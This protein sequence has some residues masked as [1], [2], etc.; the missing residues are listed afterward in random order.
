MARRFYQ[1]PSLTGLNTFDACARHGSFTAAAS[2][3]GV[4]LG[5]VSRQVKALES[6]LDCP[7]FLRLHRGVEL[8]PAGIDLFQTLSSSFQQIGRLCQEFRNRAGRAEVTLA[9]TTAFASLWLMPRIG[10]FWQKYQDINLNH[11]ISD[12]PLDSGF[13]NADIRIRYGDG[14]WRGEKTTKLFDDRIYPVCGQAFA[15][16]HDLRGADDLLKHPLLQLDSV[17]PAWSGWELPLAQWNCDI[18]RANFRRFNN[19]VVAL[20]AA[21]ENQGILLGWHSQV[22]AL[23]ERGE[24]VRI[25]T[26]EID[27]PGSFY[28]AWAENRPLSDSASRLHDW[29]LEAGKRQY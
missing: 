21:E 10:G 26:M 5:A 23:V 20:Q 1:L 17:D 16:L 11:A 19:Y 27:A 14:H 12:N 4:T 3:L 18:G 6:E 28:L 15:E 2:E 8:T 13:M 29:L 9:A 7:L 22:G 24:L 25:G